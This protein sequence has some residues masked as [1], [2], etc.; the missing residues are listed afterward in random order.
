MDE[1]K[2]DKKAHTSINL[3]E[4]KELK[5]IEL[6]SK[7]LKTVEAILENTPDGLAIKKRSEFIKSFNSDVLPYYTIEGLLDLTNLRVIKVLDQNKAPYL[8]YNIDLIKN[9]KIVSKSTKS[10]I[11]EDL[12]YYF[13]KFDDRWY[14]K[15]LSE[16]DK[17]TE[18]KAIKRIRDYIS[19]DCDRV[20]SFINDPAEKLIFT[21]NTKTYFNLF[22]NTKYLVEIPTEEKDWSTI[23]KIIFNLCEENEENYNWVI[24]WLACLYQC[25]TYRFTTSLIFIGEKGSGKG[26]LSKGLKKIYGNCS[27][28][29]NSKDLTS[30]FNSQLF[31]NKLLILANEIVDQKNKYQFSNDL[32]EFVTEETISVERKFT[33]RYQAKNYA[34]LIMFS[35]SNQPISIE[36]GDRRYFV[37]KSK[38]LDMGYSERNDFFEN[39]KYFIDQVEGFCFY[40][41]TWP[42][43][44]EL[45][46]TE[47]PMTTA[48]EEI[49]NINLTDFKAHIIDII[50]SGEVKLR[51]NMI[52]KEKRCYIILGELYNVYLELPQVRHKKVSAKK[53]ATKL[54]LEDFDVNKKTVDSHT[55]TYVDVTKYYVDESL[56]YNDMKIIL[57]KHLKE[58]I[59]YTLKEIDTILNLE[60]DI[61]NKKDIIYIIKQNKKAGILCEV[62]NGVYKLV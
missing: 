42:C 52:N 49:I 31:E 41:S 35:N 29:A 3:D 2:G 13:N 54:R 8:L 58:N 7:K 22:Q 36:E 60:Q 51:Y 37:C 46:V 30:N 34:K 5:Q 32:K 11:L 23:R 62:K 25:P 59:E 33:D 53:F 26:M 9:Y 45:V 14:L 15:I 6:D 61:T 40:L 27:Y 48:K 44:F 39:E 4:E 38:K 18:L 10:S 20:T 55:A 28:S 12:V 1:K 21:D 24:N 43:D 50:N 16:S 57:S 17:P 47:P 19:Y 56:K